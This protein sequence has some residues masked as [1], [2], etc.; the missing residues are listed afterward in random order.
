MRIALAGGMVLALALVSFPQVVINEVAWGGTK[1]SPYDE[2]IELYNPS[3]VPVDLTGWTL[4]WAGVTIYLGAE[5]GNTRVLKRHVV[6]AHGYF[7]LERGGDD[8]VV[9]RDAD[10]IYVGALPNGGAEL[11]LVDPEGDVVSTANAGCPKGWWA[12][13]KGASMERISPTASDGRFSW[14]TGIAGELKDA[15]GVPIVGSPGEVNACYLHSPRVES[16]FPSG[17]LSGVVS[18]GWSAQDPDTPAGELSVG[19]YVSYDGGATLQQVAEGLPAS[20]SYDWDTTGWEAGEVLLV[21]K[22]VDPDGFWGVATAEA[23]I[24]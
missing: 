19:L 20:G 21:V 5:D 22:A 12:G 1:A 2:W 3:D 24:E 10:L 15:D 13:G 17:E 9:G 16:E 7:L 4:T 8:T 14:R 11:R 18:W 6:P 23:E